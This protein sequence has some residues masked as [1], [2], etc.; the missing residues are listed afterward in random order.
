MKKVMLRGI[1]GRACNNIYSS[2][3]IDDVLFRLV[4]ETN[5]YYYLYLIFI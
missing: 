3:I 2:Y 4:C 1:G 5:E